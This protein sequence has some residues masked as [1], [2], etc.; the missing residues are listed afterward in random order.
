MGYCRG[1]LQGARSAECKRT[2]QTPGLGVQT[3]A[4]HPSLE[5]KPFPPPPSPPPPCVQNTRS[6]ACATPSWSACKSRR[7]RGRRRSARAWPCKSRRS[8]GPPTSTRLS[9]TRG[10][11]G[12]ERWQKRRGA[13]RSGARTRTST[14]GGGLWVGSGGALAGVIGA[15]TAARTRK[16]TDQAG[17]CSTVQCQILNRSN[18]RDLILP[19]YPYVPIAGPSVRPFALHTRTSPSPLLIT[20]HTHTRPPTTH[21]PP[22]SLQGAVSEAGRGPQAAAGGH[23]RHLLQPG[24]CGRRPAHRPQQA[25]GGGGGHQHAGAWGLLGAGRDTRGWKGGRPLV[26]H[27]APGERVLGPIEAKGRAGWGGAGLGRIGRAGLGRTARAGLS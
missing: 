23:Q 13:R 18:N 9:W 20:A 19:T 4:L 22:T 3:P 1:V 7:R 6:S 24:V 11:S 2:S 27:A 8:A 26:W 17:R 21:H 25:P 16:S 10:C 5:S 14:A 15:S 12:R